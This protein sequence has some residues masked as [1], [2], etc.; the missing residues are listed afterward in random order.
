MRQP[1]ISTLTIICV[2]VSDGS[3]P[4]SPLTLI[5]SHASCLISHHSVLLCV[6]ISLIAVK[7]DKPRASLARSS[8][9]N[10]ARELMCAWRRL[11][12]ELVIAL[13]AA[14][15]S[16][17]NDTQHREVQTPNPIY[18]SQILGPIVTGMSIQQPLTASWMRFTVQSLIGRGKELS[19]Q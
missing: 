6:L 14:H 9:V 19:G 3:I 18:S 4:K 7:Q 16:G 1:V 11:P 2:S 8:A 17:L 12:P 5:L 13:L 10:T 15:Q